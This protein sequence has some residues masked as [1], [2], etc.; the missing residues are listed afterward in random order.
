M[1]KQVAD[2]L[3]ANFTSPNVPDSNGEAAN[4]VDAL[5]GA[6]L[7]IG[8]MIAHSI[9]PRDASPG[10]DAAGGDVSSLT[11]SVMGVTAGLCKIADAIERLAEAVENQKPRKVI[12]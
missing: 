1:S 11:E 10:K 9:T 4:V 12:A 3:H 5:A 6:G 2:A 8:R 7:N